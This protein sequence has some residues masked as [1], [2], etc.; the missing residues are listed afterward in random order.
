MRSNEGFTVAAL[1]NV[2][3]DPTTTW[4]GYRSHAVLPMVNAV[5]VGYSVTVLFPGYIITWQEITL[6]VTGPVYV[7]DE[8]TAVVD[9]ETVVVVFAFPFKVIVPADPPIV[10]FGVYVLVVPELAATASIELK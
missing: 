5:A 10:N 7:I 3:L 9:A 1:S 6:P 8:F 2:I 4:S